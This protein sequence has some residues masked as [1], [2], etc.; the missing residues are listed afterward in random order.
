[1]IFDN[2]NQEEVTNITN[3]NMANKYLKR[4]DRVILQR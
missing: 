2:Q 3:K 4:I 1:M